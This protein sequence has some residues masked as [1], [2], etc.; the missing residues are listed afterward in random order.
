MYTHRVVDDINFQVN[1][2]FGWAGKIFIFQDV[3]LLLTITD[4]IPNMK[5]CFY[6]SEM[7]SDKFL[8]AEIHIGMCMDQSAADLGWETENLFL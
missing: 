5:V 6:L 3:T 1:N 2:T 4:L 7:H 8:N